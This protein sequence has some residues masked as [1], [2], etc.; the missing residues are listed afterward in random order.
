MNLLNANNMKRIYFI[1]TVCLLALSNNMLAKPEA[2]SDNAWNINDI[3]DF[4]RTY[5]KQDYNVGFLYSMLEQYGL[6]V[7]K[8]DVV[9]ENTSTQLTGNPMIKYAYLYPNLSEIRKGDSY[10]RLRLT[11]NKYPYYINDILDLVI[12]EEPPYDVYDV[13]AGFI[14]NDYVFEEVIKGEESDDIGWS[15]LWVWKLKRELDNLFVN[16]SLTVKVNDIYS[17]MKNFNLVAND[18]NEDST[19]PWADSEGRSY[20]RSLYLYSRNFEN[21]RKGDKCYS[22]QIVLDFIGKEVD[23]GKFWSMVSE[24]NTVQ[25][26]MNKTGDYYAK[27]VIITVDS[28]L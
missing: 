18:V 7:Y 4:E 17:I 21:M 10:Y 25:S 3:R 26:F 16:N 2:Y 24:D 1:V 13:M 15:T 8:A 6:E 11:V 22:I 19:S 9:L 12:A 23:K 27:K 14:C 5:K 20:L 28:K